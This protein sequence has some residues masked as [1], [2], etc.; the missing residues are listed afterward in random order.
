VQIAVRRYDQ[1]VRGLPARAIVVTNS[2]RLSAACARRW[3]L[4]EV[5]GL[6]PRTTERPLRFGGAWAQLLEDVHRWWQVH[7]RPYPEGAEDRC[8][9]CGG[10]GCMTCADAQDGAPGLGP[11][12]RTLRGWQRLQREGAALDDSWNPERDA[13]ALRRTLDGWFRS[14]GHRGP[15]EE[16]RVVGVECAF[17]APVKTP[18]G[19]AYSPQTYIVEEQPG[20][21]RLARTGEARHP[22]A[23]VVRWPWYQL[24]KLDALYQHRETG[25]L[26]VWE[27]KTSADPGGYLQGLSIDPQVPGYTWLVWQHLEAYPGAT[28]VAGYL[29]DVS[30]SAYQ[31]DPP[32][33]KAEP[34]R[35]LDANGEPV[36]AKGRNV[37]QLDANG[38]QVLRSPGLSRATSAGTVPSW[39]YQAAIAAH[40]FDP[41]EY[42]DHVARLQAEV[43]PRLYVREFGTVGSDAVHRYARELLGVASRLAQGRRDAAKAITDG[44]I[45]EAFPR[46]PVCRSGGGRCPYRGPCLEDGAL[47]RADYDVDVSITWS[48]DE[49]Q[50]INQGDLGW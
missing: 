24:G 30:S 20:R 15:P 2:E 1:P 4:S 41:T 32:L 45:A 48:T 16:Y 38:E 37:Y 6:R 14:L 19:T 3:W 36:K 21:W 10:I 44:D 5:E 7:D 35:V 27:G 11:V 8:G 40:G 25:D 23:Q 50:K 13:E 17:A 18:A 28:R 47:A 22:R 26:V 39:R 29:Y 33:L 12:A 34:V 42:R 49:E 43:D 46:T 9:W 31:A